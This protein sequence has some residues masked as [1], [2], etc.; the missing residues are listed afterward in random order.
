MGKI[1]IRELIIYV[2]LKFFSLIFR[3]FNIIDTKNKTTFVVSFGGNIQSVLHSHEKTLENQ[4][5]IILESPN[6]NIDI[7][8]F[9]SNTLCFTPK[10]FIQF[11]QSIYH[12]AT[13]S[14]ISV[15][16]YYAVLSVTNF[17]YAVKCGQLW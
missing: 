7:S 14:H 15:D 8:H 11:V 17:K 16:N 4:D 2:Y 10:K 6:S 3:I 13:S 12:L 9:N 5:T 1:M